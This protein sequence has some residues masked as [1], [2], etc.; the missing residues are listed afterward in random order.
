MFLGNVVEA[1]DANYGYAPARGPDCLLWLYHF[2][3]SYSL[4]AEVTS[5]AAGTLAVGTASTLQGILQLST[6]RRLIGKAH[7]GNGMFRVRVST[8]PFPAVSAINLKTVVAPLAA[9]Q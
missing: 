5:A 7:F 8:C 4:M 6:L 1:K 3:P 9:V 2:S